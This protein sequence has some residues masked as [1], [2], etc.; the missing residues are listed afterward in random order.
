[1]STTTE[2]TGSGL[3]ATS[4]EARDSAGKKGHRCLLFVVCLFLLFV[5]VLFCVLRKKGLTPGRHGP[6]RD[7]TK[8]KKRKVGWVCH[9]LFVASRL[10]KARQATT[11]E[12]PKHKHKRKRVRTRQK[13][14]GGNSRNS[15]TEKERGQWHPFD[16][17]T[18]PVSSSSSSFFFFNRSHHQHLS[19]SS[20]CTDQSQ[21]N[22]HIQTGNNE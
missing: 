15:T 2:T 8:K 7:W 9:R 13:G 14:P 6:R 21:K 4:T 22:R 16:E 17:E 3:E 18:K 20:T 1:M 12:R 11:K 19:F 10:T 5:F